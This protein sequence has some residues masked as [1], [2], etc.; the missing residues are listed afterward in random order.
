MVQEFPNIEFSESDRYS[1]AWLRLKEYLEKRLAYYRIQN[2]Q[3]A[4]EKETA[5]LRGR[6]AELKAVIALDEERSYE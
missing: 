4:D 6:I 5:T 2:D 3:D 1:S